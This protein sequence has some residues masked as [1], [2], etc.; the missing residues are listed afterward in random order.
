MKKILF[1]TERLMVRVADESDLDLFDEVWHCTRV[2]WNVGFPKGL[3]LTRG[4]IEGILKKQSLDDEVFNKRL[5]VLLKDSGT[6]IGEAKL[7]KPDSDGIS[8]PDV[9]LLPAFWGQGYGR[10]LMGEI[11]HYTFEN[12]EAT[13]VQTTPRVTN[14]GSHKMVEVYGGVK[15]H[16]ERIFEVPAGQ[17]AVMQEVPYYTFHVKRD[18]FLKNFGK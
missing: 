18:D 16:D 8:E 3:P 6:R 7:G 14:V 13:I 9:K 17:E 12:S 15:V 11:L 5:T 4:A 1:S 10:E 2:M